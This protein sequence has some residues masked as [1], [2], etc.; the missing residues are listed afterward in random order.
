M[1]DITTMDQ[2]PTKRPRGRPKKYVTEE[3]RLEIKRAHDRNYYQR[4]IEAKKEKVREYQAI[5][6]EYILQRKRDLYHQKKNMVNQSKSNNS[7]L[8]SGLS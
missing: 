5:N 1:T 2:L 7:D 3:E 4:N 6:K 8:I